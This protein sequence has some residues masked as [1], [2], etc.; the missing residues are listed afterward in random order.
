VSLPTV[1]AERERSCVISMSMNSFK[2]STISRE[3]YWGKHENER[4]GSRAL[5]RSTIQGP[6]G[7]VYARHEYS[8]PHREYSEISPI[9]QGLAQG[10]EDDD[11]GCYIIGGRISIRD[12]D[13]DRKFNLVQFN[14]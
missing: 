2:S 1:G 12:G 14:S 13:Q 8:C 5:F 4:G 10:K 6:E 3:F 9:D 7:H 11:N